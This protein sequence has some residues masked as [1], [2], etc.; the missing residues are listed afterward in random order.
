MRCRRA[1][2]AAATYDEVAA[3]HEVAEVGKEGL[4]NWARGLGG[5]ATNPAGL[6]ES[7]NK[8]RWVCPGGYPATEYR[9]WGSSDMRWAGKPKEN[10][11]SRPGVGRC[12]IFPAPLL[13]AKPGGVRSDSP[14]RART[15]KIGLA[16]KIEP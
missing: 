5:G 15:I 13:A 11:R 4:E 2:V 6:D 12:S 1:H 14:D 3:T 8:F 10:G 7:W 16:A 9:L